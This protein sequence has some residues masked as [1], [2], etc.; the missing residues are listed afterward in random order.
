MSVI[1]LEDIEKAAETIRGK[2]IRTP[3][4][5]ARDISQTL[6]CE[7]RLKLEN[8]QLTHAFKVRGNMNKIERLRGQCAGGVITASTGNHGQ[9]LA[10][11]A[12]TANISAKIVVPESSPKTK[13]EAIIN[14][15]AELVVIGSDYHAA[16]EHAHALAEAEGRRYVHSFDDPE[17][18]AGQGTIALEILE[19]F[20][21]VE[22]VVA[23]IGG[24]GLIA[25]ILV[26]I[27]ESRPSIK[28]V[29]V[30]TTAFPSMAESVR[31][32][33]CASVPEGKTIADGVAVRQPGQLGV[34]IVR[35]YIDDIWLVDES[36]IREAIKM[37]VGR[38]KIVPEPAGAV[39]LAG[40]LTHQKETAGLKIAAVVS[41]GNI[42]TDL[43]KEIL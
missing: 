15:G 10:L 17:I 30:Q 33:K 36:D 35:Q 29:G 32:G 40:I 9:G 31:Q 39:T 43:L 1:T 34:E 5:D 23:P 41:G 27:K 11:A 13:R 4:L 38:A 22:T 20:P 12:T 24:G 6:G 37:L 18:M 25:G 19:D 21:E 14:Y 3:L 26:A 28:V 7:L 42:D 16:C 8:F 2:V